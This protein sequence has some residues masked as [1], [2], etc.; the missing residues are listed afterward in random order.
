MLKTDKVV[1]ID[2]IVIRDAGMTVKESNLE[3]VRKQ[4]AALFGA[5]SDTVMFVYTETNSSEAI[6]RINLNNEF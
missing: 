5:P 4:V 3:V 2:R 6:T 1:R